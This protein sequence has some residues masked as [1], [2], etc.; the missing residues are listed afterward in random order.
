MIKR[1]F[2]LKNHGRFLPLKTMLI[3]I[4]VGSLW[5]LFSDM[6]LDMLITEK[7]INTTISI[8]KGWLFILITSILLY[9]LGKS[10]YK[11]ITELNT[12]MNQK[13]TE[14]E[15]HNDEIRA[16]YEQ[17]SASEE[18]LRESYDELQN[19]RLKLEESEERYKLVLSS[20]QEGFWDYDLSTKRLEISETFCKIHGFELEEEQIL[21]KTLL[22]RIHPED[23]DKVDWI[24]T[25]INAPNRDIISLEI[26]VKVK[27][28]GYRWV[29]FNVVIIRDENGKPIRFVGAISDIHDRVLQKERIE[30]YAFH[31]PVTGFYNW[32]YIAEGISSYIRNKNFEKKMVVLVVGIK[33]FERINSIFGQKISDIIHYKI[34]IEV[35]A[36]FEFIEQMGVLSKGRYGIILD[37]GLE[38]RILNA[39]QYLEEVIEKPIM[40]NQQEVSV[41]LAYGG[42]EFKEEIWEPSVLIQ[43]AETA[44]EYSQKNLNKKNFIQMFE[45]R[46]HEE[47]SY[48][49]RVE[50][51]I[52][53]ALEKGEMYLVYQPQYDGIK[54]KNIV[55]YEA[56]IRWENEELGFIPPDVFIPIAENTGQIDFIGEFVIKTACEFLSAQKK[57]GKDFK[58]SINSSF[59]ELMS[60]QYIEKLLSYTERLGLKPSDLAIEITETAISKYLDSVIENLNK[61][62]M[63]GF[64]IHLDDFGTGYSSLNH[65]GKLPVKVIKIDKSFVKVI[66]E[67]NKMK[68]LVGLV[69]QIAHRMDM[70][71]IAEG[72]ETLSQYE[73]LDSMDCDYYQGYYFSKPLK[74]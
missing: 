66:E 44:M 41:S 48:V 26:R 22:S 1:K 16:L 56:L 3:Y 28:G 18:A 20:S 25:G 74:L 55:G 8:Y 61:L 57:T 42:A 35:Q 49:G 47:Q 19:Y 29:G 46:M 32:D 39:I 7:S 21:R 68:D 38:E 34:G 9:K 73:L 58:I 31:D 5:I 2:E 23:R 71:V 67:D 72:V 52:K 24:N 53:K 33:N 37:R 69:I 70:E 12:L 59:L 43:Q 65:L 63:L 60:S 4:T 15:E 54:E 17:M 30:Y 10:D 11:E 36:A 51:L 62:K 40:I 14:L 64:E 50:Y 45:E 13:N 6:L 27:S